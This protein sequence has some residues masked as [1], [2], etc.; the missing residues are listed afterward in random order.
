MEIVDLP[1]ESIVPASWNPN[2]MTPDMLD[3]LRH[4]VEKFDLV[5]PLVVRSVGDHLYETIGGAQ[6]LSVLKQFGRESAPCVVVSV[7]DAEARL[8]GEVLN[9]VSG[10]DNLGV[11]AQ[12]LREILES[13]PVEQVLQ[14]LPESASSLQSL[15]AIGEL[16]IAQALQHWE[17]IQK[18]RL[19]HLAFQLTDGQLQVVKEV[20]QR[21]LPLTSGHQESP[22]KRGTALYLLC[23]GSLERE[24]RVDQ[25]TRQEKRL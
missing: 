14:L 11:R 12:V 9:H 7:V 10:S 16:S 8:L 1:T 25:P 13:T 15:T 6:R 4:S 23:L 21:L 19:R 18:A 22:N 24:H 17:Q 3:L 2:E 5:L 20:L